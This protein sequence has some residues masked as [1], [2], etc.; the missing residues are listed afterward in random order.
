MLLRVL[1]PAALC[2]GIIGKAGAT[3]RSFTEKSSTPTS[4][5][6]ITVSAQDRQPPGVSDR[7]V[8]IMGELD[9]SGRTGLLRA[10]NLI[11]DKLV[12]SPNYSKVTRNS[13]SYGT[14][15]YPGYGPSPS[16]APLCS[17][18]CFQPFLKGSRK[19]QGYSPI[20]LLTELMSANTQ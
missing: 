5:V 13:V 19:P 6:T 10:L 20:K 11:T 9:A 15:G 1:V 8:R 3:I 17:S 18:S 2:G 14:P 12:E 7:V 4:R 16:G